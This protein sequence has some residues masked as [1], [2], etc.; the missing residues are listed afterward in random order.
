MLSV[1]EMA[2]I[3]G[4]HRRRRGKPDSP[5]RRSHSV[6]SQTRAVTP[7]WQQLSPVAGAPHRSAGVKLSEPLVR[8]TLVGH[9]AR[10]AA[11]VRTHYRRCNSRR[12]FLPTRRSAGQVLEQR[13]VH[14]RRAVHNRWGE[15]NG[16]NGVA[17]AS[18]HFECRHRRRVDETERQVCSKD[19]ID[20]LAGSSTQQRLRS[21]FR[22]R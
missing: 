7:A 20:A 12:D 19:R 10:A 3:L 16:Y 18:G 21:L 15:L 5:K 9:V 11:T 2:R 8:R 22:L 6:A 4:A 17:E 14:G 1:N 13:R